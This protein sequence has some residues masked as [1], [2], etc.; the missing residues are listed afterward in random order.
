MFCLHNMI[1]STLWSPITHFATGT[2]APAGP[3]FFLLKAVTKAVG[4]WFKSEA[5]YG[6]IN[7]N[8]YQKKQQQDEFRM[9]AGDSTCVAGEIQWDRKERLTPRNAHCSHVCTP[10]HQEA[11]GRSGKRFAEIHGIILLKE[12]WEKRVPRPGGQEKIQRLHN[13]RV[14][15]SVVR[16]HGGKDEQGLFLPAHTYSCGSSWKRFMVSYLLWQHLCSCL[17]Q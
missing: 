2:H 6:N 13:I 8:K 17:G 11:W 12:Q 7:I 14:L 1:C 5:V 10:P 16:D 9:Q 4:S 3:A 15:G